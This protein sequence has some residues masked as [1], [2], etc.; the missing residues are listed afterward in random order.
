MEG[1]CSSCSLSFSGALSSTC[2]HQGENFTLPFF[3]CV[4][5]VKVREP[6][7]HNLDYSCCIYF[8]HILHVAHSAVD[9][10][11]RAGCEAGNMSQA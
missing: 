3:M 8:R 1:G 6:R 11:S 7:V 2:V 4:S 9:R 5:G 10:Q